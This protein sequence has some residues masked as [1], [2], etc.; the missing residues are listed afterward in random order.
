MRS[1]I[2]YSI[3]T[4]WPA[5]I[6]NVTLKIELPS[7]V[8][9]DNATLKPST[10]TDNTVTF[11][12][13]AI[14]ANTQGVITITATIDRDVKAEDTLIFGSTIN[15]TNAKKQFQSATAYLTVMVGSGACRLGIVVERTRRSVYQLVH[16]SHPRVA[17][18]IW[19]LPFLCTTKGGR[20]ICKISI[21]HCNHKKP[22]ISC[23]AFYGIRCFSSWHVI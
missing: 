21:G 15:Y 12:L 5:P 22:R 14:T 23:G 9:Y 8:Q 11:D 1:N 3:A 19:H 18:R 13:G 20:R 7:E 10:V 6:T 4:K 16:R 17:Y 2:P